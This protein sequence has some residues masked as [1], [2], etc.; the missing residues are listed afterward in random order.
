MDA[1]VL[2]AWKPQEGDKDYQLLG[3]TLL[4]LREWGRYWKKHGKGMIVIIS[5]IISVATR[6]TWFQV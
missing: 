5:K 6:K 2:T 1:P 4:E 3:Y